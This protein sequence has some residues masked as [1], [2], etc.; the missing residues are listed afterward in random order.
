VLAGGEYV[1]YRLTG[2]S[3]VTFVWQSHMPGDL[4]CDGL[5]DGA[6]ISLGCAV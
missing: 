6:D 4:N 1:S 3:V 2:K 5:I